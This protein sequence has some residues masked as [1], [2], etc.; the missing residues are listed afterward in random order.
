MVVSNILWRSL[1]IR[2]MIVICMPCRCK[3][4]ST[5]GDNIWLVECVR[6]QNSWTL[7]KLVKFSMRWLCQILYE[8]VAL[9]DSWLK[10]AWP[11]DVQNCNDNVWLIECVRLQKNSWTFSKLVQFSMRWLY[12]IFYEEV[13]L[14]DSWSIFAWL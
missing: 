4:G 11:L 14:S 6:I 8:E 2:C 13:S 5:N 9:S 7:S 10:I 1:L 12:R 3:E